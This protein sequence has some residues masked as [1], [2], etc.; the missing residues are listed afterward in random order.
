M[1]PKAREFLIVAVLLV[2]GLYFSIIGLVDAKP[3][4][5]PLSIAVLLAMV[6]LPLCNQLEKWGIGRGWSSFVS[7]LVTISFFV[8][9]FFVISMQVKSIADDWPQIKE[10]LEP[11]I[12]RLQKWISETTGIEP[13]EQK[14]IVAEKIPGSDDESNQSQQGEQSKQSGSEGQGSSGGK[15]SVGKLL[16][17]F[18]SFLGT[19]A[20]TFI[21]IFFFLLYRRKVK[22]SVLGFVPD[23]KCDKASKILNDSVLLSQ[24]YLLGRLLL[25]L[26]LAVLYSIGLFVSGID[27]AILISIIAAFLSLVPYIGNIVGF[28]LAMAMA[29]FSGAQSM[30]FVGVIITFSVAQ[31]VESYVLEPYIVGHKVKLNP[32]ITILVVV[33]GEAIWG[34]TGMIISIP[35]FGIMKIAFDQIPIFHPLGYALGEEDIEVHEQKSPFDKAGKKIKNKIS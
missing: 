34:V 4:L 8:G 9:L 30:A 12:D 15:F 28:I 26:I 16:L 10:T 13:A 5:A 18:F 35:V 11:R 33:L 6:L 24:D 23:E 22:K 32:L 14:E 19:S 29:A 25:I 21:Y 31:F 20:L 2:A 1:K 7:V 3:F 17:N 27:H